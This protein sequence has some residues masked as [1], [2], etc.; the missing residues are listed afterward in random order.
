MLVASA[1]MWGSSPGGRGALHAWTEECW[2][3]GPTIF[4]HSVVWSAV[5]TAG[6]SAPCVPVVSGNDGVQSGIFFFFEP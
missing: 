1:E 3:E 2:A 4:F 5:E 6:H